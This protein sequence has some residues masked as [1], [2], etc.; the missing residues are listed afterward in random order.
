MAELG[1]VQVF[2]RHPNHE[3]GTEHL[4]DFTYGKVRYVIP[5]DGVPRAV[6]VEAVYMIAGDW[7]K[8]DTAKDPARERER[9]RL[10]FLY[11]MFNAPFYSRTPLRTAGIVEAGEPVEDYIPTP[12][13]HLAKQVDADRTFMHPNLPHLEVVNISTQ[14]RIF[15][16]IDDPEGDYLSGKS[17]AQANMDR[18]GEQN[19]IAAIKKLERQ[20]ADLIT[21]V[22]QTNPQK[23]AALADQ[24]GIKN[25]EG[26][27]NPTAAAAASLDAGLDAPSPTASDPAAID[28]VSAMD[29][30]ND[31]LGYAA[32]DDGDDADD[33]ASTPPR[34]APPARKK[35]STR[36]AD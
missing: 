4:L 30:M 24:H 15:T 7:T 26:F 21:L 18:A 31:E 12:A 34:T 9:K 32:V 2:N 11:G 19:S 8:V 20:V 36:K 29:V 28:V 35:A 22:S 1:V 16:V 33:E 25:R 6:P 3:D 13:E 14:E 10:N 27:A 17:T 23:A 5:N